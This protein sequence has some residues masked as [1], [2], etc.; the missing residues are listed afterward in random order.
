MVGDLGKDDRG[1]RISLVVNWWGG[2]LEGKAAGLTDEDRALLSSSSGGTTPEEAR[3]ELEKHAHFKR[4]VRGENLLL[5]DAA[6]DDIRS[7]F[8]VEF[9]K[10]YELTFK[11]LAFGS[12]WEMFFE[13]LGMFCKL[14]S[15]PR[16]G[17]VD[18]EE[19]EAAVPQPDTEA[20]FAEADTDENGYITL[21]EYV[22]TMLQ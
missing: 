6:T 16:N 9:G 10:T 20:V 8:V 15:K 22:A 21:K 4:S 14:D 1:D 13:V 7:P 5:L 3:L 19:F 11:N 2:E 18:V 12:T 17:A